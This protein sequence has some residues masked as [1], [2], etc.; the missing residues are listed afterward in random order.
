MIA[1]NNYEIQ[2]VGQLSL[3][4]NFNMEAFN[5]D[6]TEVCKNF[7]EERQ[8]IKKELRVDPSFI[9]L[10][11]L[12]KEKDE[13]NE[14]DADEEDDDEDDEDEDQSEEESDIDNQSKA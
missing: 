8:K 5:L 14:K 2:N 1:L 11:K 4:N 3:L 12:E 13:N 9:L 7:F 10:K 6:F